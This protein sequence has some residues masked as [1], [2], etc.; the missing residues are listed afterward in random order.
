MRRR[1]PQEQEYDSDPSRIGG[2]EHDV[3]STYTGI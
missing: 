2:V 1:N 3:V